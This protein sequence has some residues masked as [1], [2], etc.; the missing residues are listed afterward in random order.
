M[1]HLDSIFSIFSAQKRRIEILCSCFALVVVASIPRFWWLLIL[2]IPI[3]VRLNEPP[4]AVASEDFG[5]KYVRTYDW[6]VIFPTRRQIFGI[7]TYRALGSFKASKQTPAGLQKNAEKLKNWIIFNLIS[8]VSVF[9]S[10]CRPTSQQASVYTCLL[11]LA[12]FRLHI[13][14]IWRSRS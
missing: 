12:F 7:H 4:P 10:P 6:G 3:R 11:S 2:F 13:R 14:R 8:Q 1:S 9:D 5:C